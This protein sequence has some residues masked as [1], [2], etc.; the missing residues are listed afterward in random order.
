MGLNTIVDRAFSG[1]KRAGLQRRDDGRFLRWYA[2]PK[3]A[4][5]RSGGQ[6]VLN[7]RGL[8][9]LGN[10]WR[11]EGFIK[12]DPATNFLVRL[13][14]VKRWTKE[15]IKRACLECVENGFLFDRDP[16]GRKTTVRPDRE[17]I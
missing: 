9:V 6:A 7:D 15:W 13:F 14:P 17:A 12:A 8:C 4:L 5:V 2:C 3:Q 11:Q 16:C 1:A 10:C